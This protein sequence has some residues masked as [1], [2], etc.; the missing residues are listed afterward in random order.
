MCCASAPKPGRGG[1]TR[2]LSLDRLEW[3]LVPKGP[4]G[5]R[6]RGTQ[7]LE[8]STASKTNSGTLALFLTV[9]GAVTASPSSS[10]CSLALHCRAPRAGCLAG[11]QT[12][13]ASTKTTLC[14]RERGIL[15]RHRSCDAIPHSA[16]DE[17]LRALRALRR[18][19]DNAS[20]PQE[21]GERTGTSCE[22]VGAIHLPLAPLERLPRTRRR[23]RPSLTRARSRLVGLPV[24]ASERAGHYSLVVVHIPPTFPRRERTS[25]I[26]RHGDA[27]LGTRN[28]GSACPIPISHLART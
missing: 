9:C 14:A 10:V 20:A 3:L 26:G 5:W 15:A 22:R 24:R 27:P 1:K 16:P 13:R 7:R 2:C 6:M 11:F 28:V 19:Q 17:A 23:A 4:Q 12:N 18:S 25:W 8:L 21:A